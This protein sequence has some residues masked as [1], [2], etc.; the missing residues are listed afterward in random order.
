MNIAKSVYLFIKLLMQISLFA[1]LGIAL[2]KFE[3]QSVVIIGL[4]IIV[5]LLPLRLGT[6]FSLY[7]PL[8]I[9]VL[10]IALIYGSLYLG[11]FGSYYEKFWWW[12]ILLHSG[13][14]VLFSSFGFLL[15]WILNE[16]PKVH[17]T[18]SPLFMSLFAFSFSVVTATLWEIFEFFMD[19]FFGLNMQKSG[20]VDTMWDLVVASVGGFVVAIYAYFYTKF[21]FKSFVSSWFEHFIDSNPVYFDKHS[22]DNRN[23]RE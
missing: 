2:Y 22:G 18:L 12:D 14:G 1:G 19:E 7:I 23:K 21:G 20:L 10:T 3:L 4:I 13:S 15:I 6:R 16:D 9:E 17:L 5:T 8:E 11:E